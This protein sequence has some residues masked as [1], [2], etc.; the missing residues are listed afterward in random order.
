MAKALFGHVGI[1]PDMRTSTEL[2]RLR[3]QIR[4]LEDEVARLRAVNEALAAHATVDDELI[5]LA[6]GEAEPALT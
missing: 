1:A 5:S 2:R 3:A 4:D 6:V